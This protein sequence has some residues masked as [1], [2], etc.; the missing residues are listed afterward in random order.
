MSA[1]NFSGGTGAG[2]DEQIRTTMPERYGTLEDSSNALAQLA[3]DP[4]FDNITNEYFDRSTNTKASSEL[5]YNRANE[6]E[7]FEKSRE[8]T[9]LAV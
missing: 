7:L 8:Y 4:A 9:G 5:S 3:T 2:R 6:D 1:T